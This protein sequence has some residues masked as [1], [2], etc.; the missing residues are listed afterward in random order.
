MLFSSSYQISE[1]LFMIQDLFRLKMEITR[2][3][4]TWIHIRF[5]DFSN[6]SLYDVGKYDIISLSGDADTA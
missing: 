2:G 5:S 6:L 3:E 4:Y 1:V